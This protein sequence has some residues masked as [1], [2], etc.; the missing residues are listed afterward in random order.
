MTPAFSRWIFPATDPQAAE[1]L[2][3]ALGI[4]TP[5]AKVLIN[6]GFADPDEAR[7]YLEAPLDSL[8]DPLALRD[9][10][11]AAARL[12]KAVRA[13]EKIL[14]Y[15]DY[16]VD[17]ATSVA[18][19]MKAIGMAGGDA[20]WHV[21]DRL[22]DGYGMRAETVEA[23]AAQGV[24]L[25]VSVD[26]GIRAAEVVRRAAALG[27]DVIV[28]DHHL[29]DADPPPAFAVLNPNRA[30]CAYPEKNLC[31]AGVAFKLAQAFLGRLGWPAEKLRRVSESFLKIVA[32]ATVAD[33][34]PLT[35]ENRIIVKHGLAGLSSVRNP[36]LRALFDV[37]GIAAGK[38]PSARQVA[39][40]I[41]PRINAAGRMDTAEAVIE[42]FLTAD[43]DRARE[44]A[45]QLDRQNTERRQVE[46]G[47]REACERTPVDQ[48]AAALVYYDAAWHRGVVGIVANRLM[49]RLHRPVFVLGRNAG[50]GLVQ[51][52]GRSI[53]AFHLLEA[54]DSMPD[55]FV[56]YGGHQYAAGVTL[57]EA[58]VAEFRQRFNAYA[59]ARLGPQDL[60]PMVQIDAAV[61]LREI[62]EQA[63]NG[64]YSL[65][66][67]GH[68]NPQPIFAASD[69]EVAGPPVVFGEKHLRIVVR[70][71]NRT[72][73]LK[74]WNYAA[75]AGEFAAGARIDVAFTLEEDPYSASRGYPGWCAVLR[76][77]RG[78]G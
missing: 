16:D 36:G 1:R 61:E 29:P 71:N 58:R 15:G 14:I 69:V 6:R 33:V 21:P 64:V 48:G 78:A 41:A 60:A 10:E 67:F 5:A 37:A 68:G 13:R 12:E 59:A 22:K 35:G 70:Q 75:R 74:A 55:L 49:D 27:V 66:P 17:G 30:G 38:A 45:E 63:A 77:V 52:S 72:L 53:P 18:L 39:F 32:L 3:A 24:T 2:A 62:D 23:A 11:R 76:E 73:K 43:P 34:V 50:D 44:L 57:E 51:G 20:R 54:L 28:T 8:H 7:R 4:G 46:D 40:Q 65:A 47:I 42:L 31:G 56:R 26:T 19:L 25:I 9:M